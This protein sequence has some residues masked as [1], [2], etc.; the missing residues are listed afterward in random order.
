MLKLL[1][2]AVLPVAPACHQPSRPEPTAAPQTIPP[3]P[4]PAPERIQ[5]TL[6]AH[7]REPYEVHVQVSSPRE[8]QTGW[9]R[10][11]RL[12]PGVGVGSAHGRWIEPDT[13]EIKTKG[14]ARIAFDLRQLPVRPGRRIVLRLDRQGIDLG[15]SLGPTVRFECE[16]AGVWSHVREGR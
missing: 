6:P 2:V 1:A 13:I 5:P 12:A 11:E 16:R 7:K 4:Q 8:P 14:V 9:L 10:I 15:S 3:A